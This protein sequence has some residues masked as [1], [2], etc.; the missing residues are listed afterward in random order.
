MLNYLLH[1]YRETIGQVKRQMLLR[2]TNA[3]P[4]VV[5]NKPHCDA[6]EGVLNVGTLNLWHLNPPWA[7]RRQHMV[8]FLRRV[9]PDIMGFQEVRFDGNVNQA[10][11]IADEIGDP[12]YKVAFCE[13]HPEPNAGRNEGIAIMSRHPI[14]STGSVALKGGS[15]RN[16][17]IFYA[18]I[19]V[20]IIGEILFFVTHMTYEESK[21]CAQ[22]MAVLNY[23]ETF[24]EDAIKILVGDLNIYFDF[25]W[26][27]DLATR[28][29]NKFTFH[30][31]NPCSRAAA[32]N[33]LKTGAPARYRDAWEDVYNDLSRFPGSTFP[34]FQDDRAAHLEPCRP[35]R[36]LIQNSDK[37]KSLITCDTYLF[38]QE[39]FSWSGKDAAGI[40]RQGMKMSD[41]KGVMTQ[42]VWDATQDVS[43]AEKNK[44][45]R[46]WLAPVIRPAQP[47]V[48]TSSPE[49]FISLHNGVTPQLRRAA[50]IDTSLPAYL[51]FAPDFAFDADPRTFFWSSRA[52]ET[53]EKFT[54]VLS[55]PSIARQVEI[56]TGING[57]DKVVHARF[58]ASKAKSCA[59]PVVTR[60]LNAD[61]KAL[62]ELLNPTK[63]ACVQ[64]V[65]DEPQENWVVISDIRID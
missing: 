8:E 23:L 45:V 29:V 48:K 63:I 4:V 64:L 47:L 34:N 15:P 53:G 6:K 16:R 9:K 3:D 42:L 20:P 54:V 44:R 60:K 25:E 50:S 12:R 57:Q 22:M 28:P 10:Q 26:P 61:G 55:E 36:I 7:L 37:A 41:H 49:R 40:P 38:G 32:E 59:S 2:V 46:D 18:R 13:V 21:Q 35:D 30:K 52:P 14:I 1:K 11:Q 56:T 58:I 31:Y 39:T 65:I 27:L 51:S 19:N 62:L 5:Q 17:R 43:Y 33:G 24:D